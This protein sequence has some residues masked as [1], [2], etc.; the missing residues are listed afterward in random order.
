MIIR[1]KLRHPKGLS[2]PTT[3]TA[4][5]IWFKLTSPQEETSWIKL[6]LANVNDVNDLKEAIKNKKPV[7]LKDHD[8][9][10]LILKA[11]KGTESDEQAQEL[12]NSRESVLSLQERFGNDF[13][14]LVFLP[15]GK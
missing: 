7:D 8:A 14:I 11:K 5:I 12:N 9:D 4:Q 2:L 6:S 1:L 3:M 13:E 10:R 15:A